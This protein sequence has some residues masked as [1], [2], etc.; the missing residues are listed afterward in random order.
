[1]TEDEKKAVDSAKGPANPQIIVRALGPASLEEAFGPDPG[2][3]AESP[4][5]P[6]HMDTVLKAAQKLADVGL[7]PDAAKRQASPDESVRIS[8]PGELSGNLADHLIRISQEGPGHACPYQES[9][10]G[11]SRKGCTRSYGG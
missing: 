5:N 4:A 6:Q 2:K 1:M 10:P 9:P 3:E 8:T 7:L 11:G